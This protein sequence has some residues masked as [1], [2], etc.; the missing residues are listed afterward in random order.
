MHQCKITTQIRDS[1]FMKRTALILVLALVFLEWLDF[2]LYLYL[3]KSVF[4]L[5]FFPS[6]SYSLMLTF[7]L[8]AAAY[9]ARPLGGWIF[10]RRADL[11]GRRKPMLLSAGLM[12]LATLGICILPGYAQIGAW[13][14]WGLLCLRAL[15]GLALGGEINTSAMF[16]VEHHPKTPLIAGSLVAASSALGMFLGGAIAAILQYD[17]MPG[18][19][20]VVFAM[21]GFCSLI[22]CCLRKNLEESPEFKPASAHVMTEWRAH[23]DGIFNIAIVAAFISVTVYLC[24]IY[25][26]SFAIDQ[27]F[28]SR[29]FCAWT[30]AFAQLFA[31]L[32][33]ILIAYYARPFQTFGLIIASMVLISIVAPCL[34]YFTTHH[35]MFE[36]LIMIVGYAVA[37]AMFS[38]CLYY[39][40]YTQL[41]SQYRCSGVSTVWAIAASLG[42]ISLPLASQGVSLGARCFPGLLVTL[43]ALMG[44]YFLLRNRRVMVVK[45]GGN[46]SLAGLGTD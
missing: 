21:V 1:L 43:I 37:N 20:R 40:L 30:G 38:S 27:G 36:T 42:A 8:F 33:A 22:V 11:T 29:T 46:N 18:A 35:L 32:L 4:S 28:A 16:M 15:Q 14:T 3:A 10:G 25:W 26:V 31:A 9:L 34:F 7:A 23:K 5:V 13:S 17:L 2:S 44:L 24:N 19:W 12:G 39:F 6:S 45:W 41:P